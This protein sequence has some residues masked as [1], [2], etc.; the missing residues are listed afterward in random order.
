MAYRHW[1][2]SLN[3]GRK[4]RRLGAPRLKSR[5]DRRQS[6]RFTTAARFRVIERADGTTSVRLSKIGDV[7]FVVSRPLPSEPSSVTL[8]HDADGRWHVSFVVD[9]PVEYG[10]AQRPRRACGVDLGLK[11]F[12][13]VVGRDLTTGAQSVEKIPAPVLL[14]RRLRALKRSQRALSRKRNGSHRRERQRLRVAAQHRKVRDARSDHAHQLAARL[15]ATHDLVVTEDLASAGF[16]RNRRLARSAADQGLG[17]FLAHVTH[18]ARKRAK[19]HHRIGRFVPS[20]QACSCCGAL[21]GPKGLAELG[22]RQWA[23]R[24][25]TAHDRDI[26]AARN[27]LN[28][29]LIDL[30]LE[31]TTHAAA[32]LTE[33]Q[34]APRASGRSDRSGGG[35]V[36]PVAFEAQADPY[37]TG[38]ITGAALA[39]GS[40]RVNRESP[41]F[42]AGS[43]NL[44]KL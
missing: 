34:N 16:A 31:P 28:Q 7:R 9:A 39:A 3:G 14:R 22:V 25:G 38:R 23:C 2:R 13:V 6:A 33:A 10:P 27:I 5:R 41:P 8:I 44:T 1:F 19:L 43:V 15:T 20:T 32:G 40:P 36:R 17:M 11:D 26:N 37:E 30:G 18:H 24:C 35:T 42:T 4:G 29:G 21:S 12:A